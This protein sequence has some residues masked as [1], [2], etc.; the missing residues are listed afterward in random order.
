VVKQLLLGNVMRTASHSATVLLGC[1]Y[2]AALYLNMC[3]QLAYLA[4]VELS[5]EQLDVPS[6][7]SDMDT[8]RGIRV[9]PCPAAFCL[10]RHADAEP[11]HVHLRI[12][13]MR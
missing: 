7:S 12:P 10:A 5:L 11:S 13:G 9:I 2:V 4:E 6:A 3:V 1:R 8:L